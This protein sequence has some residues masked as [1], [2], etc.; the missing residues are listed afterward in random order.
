MK[1]R[2]LDL[3]GKR[4]RGVVLSTFHSLGLRFLREEYRRAG[5]SKGFTILDEDDQLSAVNDLMGDA[6]FDT[7]VY[8]LRI[9]HSVIGHF[10]SRLERPDPRRGGIEGVAAH[11]SPLYGRRLRAMNTVDF[12]DLIALPVWL[13][14]S[15]EEL[16]YRW[17]SRFRYIMVDEYQDTNLSQLRL[18]KALGKR[19]GNICVVGDDDQSIYGWRGAEAGN[20]L[21]FD[22]HFAGARTIALTQNYRSTNRILKSAN[23]LITNNAE[24]HE[25][26][27]WSELGEGDALRYY[28]APDGD[29]EA[30]WVSAD[31]LSSAREKDLPWKSFSILY[32]TN[33]QSRL[34]EDS[35]R[36]LDIPY[37]IIGGTRF[38][39]RKEVK[40]LMAYL[41]CIANPWDESALRRIINFPARGIGDATIQKIANAAQE[42]SVPFF[43]FL[44]DPQ[45]VPGL[46]GPV[47]DRFDNLTHFSKNFVTGFLKQTRNLASSDAS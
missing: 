32:R 37:R 13:L 40:D 16:A 17:A 19:H 20:I 8:D 1:E 24:R 9:V 41:R 6:G 4:A 30:R 3:A 22:E 34:V 39:D 25:K 47:L 31:L 12:D 18:L 27:L 11:L 5:L 33:A 43:R 35:L 28:E 26:S 7:G 10:K 42:E 23:A 45:R 15:D 44:K 29:E 14:E 21:R 2:V 36:A 46:K 38:Y